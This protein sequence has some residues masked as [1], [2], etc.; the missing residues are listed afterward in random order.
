MRHIVFDCDGTLVAS[1]SG[2]V[3]AMCDVFSQHFGR[4][5]GTLEIEK[6]FDPDTKKM[7]HNM[8]IDDDKTRNDLFFEWGKTIS[9]YDTKHNLFEGI[10]E[11]LDQLQLEN[12]KLYV[13][14]GRDRNSTVSI[15]KQLNILSLFEDINTATD[16]SPIPSPAGLEYML[17]GVEKENI[18][19]IGDSY[20]DMLGAKHFG[21]AKIGALWC[22]SASKEILEEYNADYL[23]RSP[24]E[25]LKIINNWS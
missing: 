2:V 14:T 3:Q 6:K 16:S 21:C 5:V 17:T 19:V 18:I 8:G 20:T 15:L 22:K 9:H 11:L 4:T 10:K 23:A 24:G 25:C 13:W 12:Y 7:F 1:I